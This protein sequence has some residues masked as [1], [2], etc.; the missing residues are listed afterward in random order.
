MS[1]ILDYNNYTYNDNIFN[2]IYDSLFKHAKTE[3]I[4]ILDTNNNKIWNQYFINN[5]SKIYNINDINNDLLL[6][7]I[8]F[9]DH[10]IFLSM[11]D[12]IISKLKNGGIIIIENL[13]N[14]LNEHEF[15]NNNFI[16]ILNEFQE[17]YFI[18]INHNNYNQNNNKLLLLI[19]NGFS[20]FNKNN[21]IT[22]ITPC[23]RPYNLFYI[24]DNINF[25][26]VDEWLIIYD[27]N[28]IPNNLNLFLQY[29]KI[30]EHIYT[31]DGISGNPQR[32]Y[33]LDI[34][35]NKNKLIY[36]LDDDNIINKNLYLLLNI[37]DDEFFYSFNMKYLFN[38]KNNIL[39]G[40]YKQ[41]PY[42]DT[43][44]F[45]IPNKL[46]ENIKWEI[47]LYNADQKYIFDINAKN[48][49]KH[50]YCNN[51]LSYYN[52]LTLI[53]DIN[54]Y[55]ID[56]SFFNNIF[57]LNNIIYLDISINFNKNLEFIINN[58]NIDI[59]L[60]CLEH[61]DNIKDNLI[62]LLTNVNTD[63]LMYTKTHYFNINISSI[64]KLYNIISFNGNTFYNDY[65]NILKYYYSVLD[66]FFIYIVYNWNNIIHNNTINS[67]NNLKIKILYQTKINDN[68]Y[69]LI[70]EK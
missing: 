18:T 51:I 3:I 41:L 33:G 10:N 60:I 57:N 7:I 25:D 11:K 23:T 40:N 30:K 68:T 5:L 61:E 22:I 56:N 20:L 31:N 38:N 1:L 14:T 26:Y 29:D 34:I 63:Q 35:S 19:K 2:F 16:N 65:L 64:N 46:S 8:I 69:L 6:D 12:N 37:I 48:N 70:L 15:I 24:K 17:Y 67:I 42:M 39:Y 58:K 53:N 13:L 49:N 54:S 9:H 44:M 66:S 59:T 55:I 45:L 50:I 52:C 27:K 4:N 47:Q 62:N 43:S 28:K 21:K 32:N 36:Y